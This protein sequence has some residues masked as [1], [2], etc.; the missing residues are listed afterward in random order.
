MLIT[1]IGYTSTTCRTPGKPSEPSFTIIGTRSW[2]WTYRLLGC[3]EG[4]IRLPGFNRV[5][6]VP[7]LQSTSGGL[8]NCPHSEARQRVAAD[9]NHPKYDFF[10]TR[11]GWWPTRRPRGPV[12]ALGA[13]PVVLV[14]GFEPSG[15]DQCPLSD[16]PARPIRRLIR[17]SC[18]ALTDGACA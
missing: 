6:P 4:A 13:G 1:T 16:G 3:F 8:R 18:S 17:S 12:G 2:S 15:P 5:P 7:P 14:P 9:Q 10:K 11:A